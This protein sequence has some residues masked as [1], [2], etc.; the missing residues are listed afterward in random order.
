MPLTDIQATLA[1]LNL[2]HSP[3]MLSEKL[4]DRAT[5]TGILQTTLQAKET[6]LI[7]SNAIAGA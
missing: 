1:Y 7:G 3:N 4:R 5:G 2:Y 6:T